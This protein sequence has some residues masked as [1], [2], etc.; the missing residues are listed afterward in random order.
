MANSTSL[1]REAFMAQVRRGLFDRKAYVFSDSVSCLGDS[2]VDSSSFCF[3][4]ALVSS[5]S[6][7]LS[8]SFSTSDSSLELTN[9]DD[10]ALRFLPFSLG[11][12]AIGLAGS[13]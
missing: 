9:S 12:L 6:V 11:C 13:R 1:L 3:D 5:I 10:N 2:L 8:L 7:P 4:L